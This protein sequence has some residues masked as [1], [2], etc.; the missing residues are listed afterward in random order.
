MTDAKEPKV[1]KG[2]RGFIET[3]AAPPFR[4]ERYREILAAY[5]TLTRE[6]DEAVKRRREIDDEA[7][8]YAEQIETLR[9][10]LAAAREVIEFARIELGGEERDGSE[11]T[12]WC[13]A[14]D[15]HVDGNHVVRNMLVAA[16]RALEEDA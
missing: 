11:H 16:L 15:D 7:F 5:D 10:Q 14:C 8:D 1:I 9:T 4:I 2:I 12:H 13:V 6:R 3:E